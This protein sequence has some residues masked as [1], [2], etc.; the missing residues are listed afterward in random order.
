MPEVIAPTH[1]DVQVPAQSDYD[2]EFQLTDLDGVVV[3]ISSDTITLVVYLR[4]TDV[5]PMIEMENGPGQHSVPTQGKTKFTFVPADSAWM[6]RSEELALYEVWRTYDAGRR[7][8]WIRGGMLF[9]RVRGT[10]TL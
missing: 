1:L 7:F 6:I 8:P 10:G 3:D 5:T 2:L 4:H 9:T